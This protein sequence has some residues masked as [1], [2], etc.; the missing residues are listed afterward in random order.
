[1]SAVE[2]Q[3]ASSIPATIGVAVG[4]SQLPVVDNVAS[5]RRRRSPEPRIAADPLLRRAS[6]SPLIDG[7]DAPQS[8]ISVLIQ[9]LRE[10][11]TA[12]GELSR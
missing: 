10:K 11:G 4:T 6:T 9:R 2:L 3:K 7:D 8:L 1:V 5:R 12:S